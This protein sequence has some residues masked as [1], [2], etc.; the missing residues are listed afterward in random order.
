MSFIPVINFHMSHDPSNIILICWFGAQESF[1]S[2][3]NVDISW[4]FCGNYDAFLQNRKRTA[5]I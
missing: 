2:I 5:F 4:C 3:I 1:L